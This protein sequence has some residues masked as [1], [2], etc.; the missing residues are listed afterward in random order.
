[1]NR[2]IIFLF[3]F[4]LCFCSSHAHKTK[5]L[6]CDD[7]FGADHSPNRP[8]DG[9]YH[10]TDRVLYYEKTNEESY[11]VHFPFGNSIATQLNGDVLSTAYPLG[12]REQVGNDGKTLFYR[13]MFRIYQI[14]IKT[15]VLTDFYLYHVSLEDYS[16]NLK[17]SSLLSTN[18]PVFTLIEKEMPE[19]YIKITLGRNQ[20][21]WQCYEISYLKYLLFIL[22]NILYGIAD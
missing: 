10:Y 20:V 7:L 2:I 16:K 15:R 6:V 9:V 14:N 22:H 8:Y 19:N 3:P 13:E 5:Y 11:K 17:D 18:D 12:A 4:V 1:M 21:S